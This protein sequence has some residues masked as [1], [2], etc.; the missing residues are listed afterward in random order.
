[1]KQKYT[2][3]LNGEAL[4]FNSPAPDSHDAPSIISIMEGSE[5]NQLKKALQILEKKKSVCL[6]L[7]SG[8]EGI[9][10]LK[11]I[12]SC[13]PASGGIV[14]GPSGKILLIFRL[15]HWDLPKGKPDP[16]ELPANT[17]KREIFEETNILAGDPLNMVGRTW[18]LYE[19]NHELVLKE[20]HWFY[21]KTSTEQKPLPQ[22]EE[23]IQKAEWMS[24]NEIQSIRN[25]MYPS[26]RDILDLHF[27]RV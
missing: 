10:Q 19:S 15:G 1:M 22:R 24:N 20:T 12:I 11:T 13:V 2:V 9:A 23:D 16:D 27:S 6:P 25:Q 8:E 21:F 26:V 17:A 4:I 5:I 14:E 3:Y 7:I 18:H